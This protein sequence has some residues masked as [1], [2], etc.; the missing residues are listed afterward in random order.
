[1]VIYGTGLRGM[2]RRNVDVIMLLLREGWDMK[3]GRRALNSISRGNV[4]RSLKKPQVVRVVL[5][6]R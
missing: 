6:G 1:M 5:S 2:G 4:R 3:R